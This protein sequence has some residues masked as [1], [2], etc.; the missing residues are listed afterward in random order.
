MKR[1]LSLGVFVVAVLA[2]QLTSTAQSPSGP[3]G[4]Q[5]P[6]P[7]VVASPFSVAKFAPKRTGKAEMPPEAYNGY[8][9]FRSAPDLGGPGSAGSGFHHFSL[10]M[11]KYT[12]WYRPRAATLTQYQRCAP[13]SFR[14]KGLGHLFARPC[15]GYRMEYEPYM[16]S[17]GMSTYGPSYFAQMPDPRCP[18]C[19]HT[20]DDC[21]QC[22]SCRKSRLFHR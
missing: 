17:D 6:A 21:E 7:G 18:D 1:A 13:D 22:D 4:T 19:D 3:N 12:N 9:Q 14:P 2:L 11:D 15:D 20:A 5:L 16:L 10:P 8:A